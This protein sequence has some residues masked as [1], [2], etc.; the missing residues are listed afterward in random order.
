MMTSEPSANQQ[1]PQEFGACALIE[2]LLPLYLEGEVSPGSRDAIVEHLAACERCAGF[3]AGAQNAR[4]RL[5]HLPP[6][7]AMPGSPPAWMGEQPGPP[8]AAHGGVRKRSR[9]ALLLA[10]TLLGGLV[11]FCL[12]G[13]A[14]VGGVDSAPV[15]MQ[16]YPASGFSE[17]DGAAHEL[18]FPQEE[19]GPERPFGLK[20]TRPLRDR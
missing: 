17:R 9:P 6:K 18:E 11:F 7:G 12:A 3:L 8:P 1:A 4:A 2:D 10:L 14:L 20:N 16:A 19:A 13:F 5:H 15:A